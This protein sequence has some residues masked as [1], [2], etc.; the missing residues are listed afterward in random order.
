MY[1]ETS[2]IKIIYHRTCRIHDLL[3]KRCF[4][5]LSK[6]KATCIVRLINHYTTLRQ[7]SFAVGPELHMQEAK[8]C[9]QCFQNDL[10]R[11]L[12]KNTFKDFCTW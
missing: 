12:A 1:K 7:K 6:T 10:N 8:K 5:I 11:K 4:G 3:L 9:A 2:Y